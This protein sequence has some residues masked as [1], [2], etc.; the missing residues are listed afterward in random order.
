M[1][2]DRRLQQ[3]V[4]NELTADPSVNA[5]KIGVSVSG[6]IVTLTGKVESFYEKWQAEKAA[7]RV[8][9]VQGLTV[10]MDVAIP[11]DRQRTDE[12][13]ARSVQTVLGWNAAIPKDSVKV[14]VE[15]GWVTLRGELGWN[16]QRE[17]AEKIVTELIGVRGVTD[18]IDLKPHVCGEHVKDQIDAAI[19]RQAVMDAQKITVKVDGG[20]VMLEGTVSNWAE[21]D[22]IKHAVWSTAGVQALVDK[23]QYDVSTIRNY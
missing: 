6:G 22:V 4:L 1:N 19:R 12:A 16:F 14:M 20:K 2:D 23:M 10:A 9:G 13:I 11:S 8:L 17:M 7:Q 18:Q 3:E 5:E 15:N 21:R